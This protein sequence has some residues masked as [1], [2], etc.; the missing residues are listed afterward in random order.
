MNIENFDLNLLVCFDALM[1]E[2]NVSRAA[3]QIHISQPAMS[4]SLKRL[5]GVLDDPLLVRTTY[6][7]EPTER[8]LE[9][10][11]LVRQSLS[12]AEAALSPTDHFEPKTT[13]RVFRI[14]VSDYVEG[15]LISSLVSFLQQHAPEISLDILTLS[16]ASFQDLEKGKVDLAI[17]SF[18]HIPQSFHQR[19][20]WKD[21]FSCLVNSQ[22]SLIENNTLENYLAAGHI[23]VSKTGIG[24]ATGMS[25]ESIHKRA[26]VDEALMT[27][28]CER[29]IRVF[30][31]HYQ[32][33]PLLVNNTDLIATLPTRAA[34]LYQHHPTLAIVD[35][36]FAIEP[37]E[38]KM[39]WSSLLQHNSA[40]R[41]IRSTLVDLAENSML[42]K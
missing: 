14:L 21:S 4:N 5:R 2:R 25:Q 36:P 40:H 9:L 13:Q 30:S 26:W 17:N 32:N 35:P 10:E 1:R 39:V 29:N 12:F 38:I 41:W 22:H 19:L 16:D 23:W 8:A 24:V 33:V 3:E 7:M 34:L 42:L 31:R 37:I 6:G 15:T 11:P 18:D 20:I 28:N 27:L